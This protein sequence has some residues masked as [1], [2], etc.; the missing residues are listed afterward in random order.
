MAGLLRVMVVVIQVYAITRRTEYY[1][2]SV[3]VCYSY[4]DIVMASQFISVY[5]VLLA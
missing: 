3:S 2:R 5:I 1:L 4:R